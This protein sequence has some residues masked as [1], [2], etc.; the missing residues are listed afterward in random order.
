[1][2]NFPW[3]RKYPDWDM[4]FT[5]MNSFNPNH[6]PNVT[7]ILQIS[8]CKLTFCKQKL[9]EVQSNFKATGLLSIICNCRNQNK[10]IPNQPTCHSIN[11]E[12]CIHRN[13]ENFNY[14]IYLQWTNLKRGFL[15]GSVQFSRSVVSNSLQPREPQHARPPC[16]SP[17]PRVYTD[18]CPLSWWCHPT[19]IL[20]HPLLFLPLIC[21]SI[22]VFLNES[23]LHIRCPK[24]WSFS[25]NITP[26]NEYS[27]LI[28]FRMDWLYSLAAQGTLESLLQ[29]HSSI[30]SILQCS[31]FFISPTLTSIH[32]HWRNHSLD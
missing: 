16:P 14:L 30:A 12:T 15:G 4:L 3:T 32:D 2:L 13:F 24:Y 27:G 19:I 25:F 11:C 8:I 28:S 18:S 21:P 9:R 6:K 7:L 20:C 29:H 1:M 23:A 5:F 10:A 22:R 26:S 31:A 17:T